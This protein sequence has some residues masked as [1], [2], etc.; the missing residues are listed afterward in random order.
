MARAG[1]ATAPHPPHRPGQTGDHLLLNT[2]IH[3]IN[4]PRLAINPSRRSRRA[5]VLGADRP[6]ILTHSPTLRQAQQ[7]GFA[8]TL[9]KAGRHLDELAARL[10]RGR[11][12]R[13]RPAVQADLDRALAPR[14]VARVLRTELT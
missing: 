6:V 13:A 14:W 7:V 12:R 8:Q 9:A 11:T 2:Q 10:A 4:D 5:A 1:S 3:P